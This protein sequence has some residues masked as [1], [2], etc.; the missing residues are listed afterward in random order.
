MLSSLLNNKEI[1]RMF[2]SNPSKSAASNQEHV[3]A[4]KAYASYTTANPNPIKRWSHQRRLANCCRIV[5]PKPGDRILDFGTGDGELLVALDRVCPSA[6]L[7]GFEPLSNADQAEAIAGQVAVI[8]RVA[9][10]LSPASFNKVTC[11]DVLEHLP[12]PYLTEAIGHLKRVVAPG[13]VVLISAPIEDGLSSLFKNIIRAAAG[14]AHRNTTLS[15]VLN[16]S[17]GR[18]SAIKRIPDTPGWVASHIGFS[19]RYVRDRLR[20]EGLKLERT[21]FS[22][23]PALG[24]LCNSQVL[25]RFRVGN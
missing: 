23:L 15:S 25:M 18:T 24:P 9:D 5:D 10:K 12:E 7:T 2:G 8:Y 4:P 21:T 16:S 3:T 19:W 14:Q 22:P 17:I 1:N 11:N 13:G 20:R 6:L